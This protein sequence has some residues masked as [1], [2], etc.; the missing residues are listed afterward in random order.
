MKFLAIAAA[1]L[2]ALT[3][4]SFL[5]QVIPAAPRAHAVVAPPPPDPRLVM[6]EDRKDDLLKR[7]AICE[8]GDWGPSEKRIYGGNGVFHGRFQFMIRTVQGF[9][10]QIDGEALTIRQATD[11]AHDWERA[12]SLA[13]YV[14]FELDGITH[15]PLCNRKLGLAAEVRAIKA[16]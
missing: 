12:S 7:L 14:I 15:W 13:K 9:V 8:S 2:A 16:L 3:G 5:Q 1:M 6:I 11:L 10:L 4:C